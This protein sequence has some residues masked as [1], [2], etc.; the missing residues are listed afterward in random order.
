M[1]S[2]L[3][4][5]GLDQV[6]DFKLDQWGIEP[7]RKEEPW[8]AYSARV[9]VMRPTLSTSFAACCVLSRR[10]GDDGGGEGSARRQAGPA[11]FRAKKEQ[12]KKS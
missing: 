10:V 2:S 1:S 12:P 8:A 3:S 5:N 9:Q 6:Y 7:R 11:R 4:N